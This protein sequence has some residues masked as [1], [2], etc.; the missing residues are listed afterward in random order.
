MEALSALYLYFVSIIAILH[1]M[2]H[3]RSITKNWGLQWIS[4][5][6]KQTDTFVK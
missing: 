2:C 3:C 6:V 5:G 1:D 4:V